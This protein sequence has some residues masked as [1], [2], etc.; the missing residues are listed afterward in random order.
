LY[1][2]RTSIKGVT[3]EGISMGG[4]NK[5][6]AGLPKYGDGPLR[7]FLIAE[8]VVLLKSWSCEGDEYRKN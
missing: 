4:E 5:K 1:N 2:K 7:A 6:K 8:L 3:E